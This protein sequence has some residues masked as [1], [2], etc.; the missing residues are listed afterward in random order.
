MLAVSPATI[1]RELKRNIDQLGY[2]P[3][4]VQSRADNRR[5]EATKG[6]NMT[7]EVIGKILLD[8]CLE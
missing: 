6:V 1:C 4:Q 3:K 2:R 7:E 5:T 8:L